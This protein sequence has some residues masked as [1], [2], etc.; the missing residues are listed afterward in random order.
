MKKQN[1][2]SNLNFAE[3][4]TFILDNKDNVNPNLEEFFLETFETLTKEPRIVSIIS[5]N[6]IQK[7][8]YLATIF[9]NEKVDIKED[10]L[11]NYEKHTKF[12]GVLLTKTPDEPCIFLIENQKYSENCELFS[13]ASG[14][15]ILYL[16][17]LKELHNF[18]IEQFYKNILS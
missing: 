14:E 10:S 9:G 1:E 13:I 5:Y 4:S 7:N 11:S 8:K 6:K 2:N 17:N 3:K 16:L 15:L 12:E 18:D